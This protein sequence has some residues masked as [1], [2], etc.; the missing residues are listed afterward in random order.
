MDY[1]AAQ[2]F[3]RDLH[4]SWWNDT[5]DHEY[6]D[7]DHGILL[8][9]VQD[10]VCFIS[11]GSAVSSILPWWRLDHI[12]SSMKPDLRHGGYGNALLRAIEVSSHM[13]EAGPP[14]L[15]DRLRDFASRLA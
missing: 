12:G 1:D 3:A 14:N 13:L 2:M 4:D 10:C 7:A 9:P 11:P 8:L 6:H 5:T 15:S